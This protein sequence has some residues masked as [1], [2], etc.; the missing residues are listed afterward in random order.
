[1]SASEAA[2]RFSA[3]LDGAE[4]GETVV[5][6]RGGRRVALIVPAPRANGGVVAEV[7]DR[8]RDQLGLDD[9]FAANV[10]S[11]GDVPVALDGDPWR[12]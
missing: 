8:W 2:R 10:A 12:G 4:Q 3:V 9:E 7:L 6:T 11:A 5:I 1:M